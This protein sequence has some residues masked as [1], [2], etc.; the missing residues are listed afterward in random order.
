MLTHP[1]ETLEAARA[2]IAQHQ[3]QLLQLRKLVS[4]L[5]PEE[6][7]QMLS[8]GEA[9]IGMQARHLLD[10]VQALLEGC[11]ADARP[12]RVQYGARH[13]GAPE[14]RCPERAVQRID[15]LL[16]TLQALAPETLAL[17]AEVLLAGQTLA[18][19]QATSVASSV[20]RELL[21]VASHCTHHLAIIRLLVG[22][23]GY[24]TDP[25]VGV[26][27]ATQ[28]FRQSLQTCPR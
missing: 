27:P 26:A 3:Q 21:Y 8:P 4:R 23:L 11:A 12:V 28:L 13:R 16:A 14:E 10:A 2:L 7:G 9:S 6:Y 25:D 15:A 18:P 20:V 24:E 19:L 17:P 1:A 5:E 22:Q